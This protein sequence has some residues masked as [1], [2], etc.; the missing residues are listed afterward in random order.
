[1]RL[2]ARR[3]VVF[4]VS[5]MMIKR[6]LLAGLLLT[7]AAGASVSAQ[8]GG[9][10]L[11]IAD[12]TSQELI[13][14]TRNFAL[15]PAGRLELD[16]FPHTAFVRT[17]S[18]S[19][20]VTDSG[21]AA[22]AIARGIKADNRVIGM[23]APDSTGS[24]ASLL[25]LAR[26][27][28][29]ST[30]IVT[31][32]SVT[33]ATPAAFLVEHPNRNQPDQIARKILPQLGPRADLVMGGGTRWFQDLS[34]KPGAAYAPGQLPIVQS[35]A[36]ALKAAPVKVFDSWEA[37]RD[38]RPEKGASAPVLGTFHPDVFPFHADSKRTL[39]LR[40][41]VEKAVELLRAREKPFFLMVEAG[42]PDKACHQNQ[43]RRAFGEVMELDATLA[44]LREN[45][46][47][48]TLV[49]VTTD[50]STG[51][52][53]FS[54]PSA[55]VKLRGDALLGV[56]PLNNFEYLTW[57]SGPGANRE[58]AN[59]RPA[60]TSGAPAPA[61]AKLPTDPD[62]MQPALVPAGSASHTGGDVWLVAGGPGSE[63]FSGSL[64]NT[65]IYRLL[66]GAISRPGR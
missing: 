58:T 37:L 9:I 25:D 13:T 2:A 50:H 29:W 41:M 18:A 39:R 60:P 48:D 3:F 65:D 52:L 22:T 57:A 45:L 11:V 43:A 19:D 24:P 33:G 17:Y 35:T 55:P 6:I 20:L 46:T 59:V 28:G 31:D 4:D 63:T 12:G 42:L 64:D 38:Y 49:V 56:N 27:A 16:K 15:G 10:V 44:W 1:M 66:A 23:A 61:E 36:A 32:D 53:A 30:G 5:P 26:N 14:A 34:G 8:P 51:G 62:Y 21:A 47:P 40:D 7:A 54:G